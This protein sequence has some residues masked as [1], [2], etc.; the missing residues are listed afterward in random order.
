MQRAQVRDAGPV[1]IPAVETVVGC[2]ITATLFIRSRRCECR[3]DVEVGNQSC[4][5]SN[6]VGEV[7][8]L[9]CR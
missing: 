7:W 5:I 9:L 1:I 4:C 8:R 6:K 3:G 2:I